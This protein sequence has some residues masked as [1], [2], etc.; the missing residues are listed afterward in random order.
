MSRLVVRSLLCSSGRLQLP[1]TV[2]LTR[3]DLMTSRAM[4]QMSG[5]TVLSEGYSLEKGFKEKNKAELG[6]ICSSLSSAR[7]E[8]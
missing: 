2:F 4:K 1:C 3:L 7:D 8:T 6:C 5:W